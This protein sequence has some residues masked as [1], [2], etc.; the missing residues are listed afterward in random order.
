MK[1]LIA[2]DHGLFRDSMATWLKSYSNAFDIM[3]A[4]DWQSLIKKL[5]SAPSLVML[6]L[7]MP[8]MSGILS[9]CELTKQWP[10]IPFL[11]VSATDD[12]MIINACIECGAKGYI[13]KASDGQEIIKA[14]SN[15]LDGG[16]YQTVV[17]SQS[18]HKKANH[19]LNKKQLQI[20]AYLAEGLS[21]KDIAKKLHFSEGTV[22]QYVSQLLTSLN[23]D[24]RTQAANQ[25]KK[26]L[27]N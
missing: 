6:D 17:A 27:G 19:T 1:I 26:F 15:I 5:E 21:N 22:K 14:V 11:I 3:L 10:M 23:V 7:E 16:S 24:N 12:P 20:L 13:T 8:G 25:A 9:L 2:D 18:H 4:S